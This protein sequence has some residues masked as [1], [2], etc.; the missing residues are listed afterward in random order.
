MPITCCATL[1]FNDK[2]EILVGKRLCN[3]SSNGLLQLPGGKID[4][5]EELEN[6]AIRELREE[7]NLN[8]IELKL[9]SIEQVIN[10]EEKFHYI[11]YIYSVTKWEGQ[12]TNN[13]PNKCEYWRWMSISD[14]KK[15]K[16]I[17]SLRQL[18]DTCSFNS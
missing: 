12:L 18:V 4:E 10:K 2:Q 1:L 9:C 6:C 3:D 17:G 7:T 11:V 15:E 5:Y 8:A 16:L 14:V 13:E